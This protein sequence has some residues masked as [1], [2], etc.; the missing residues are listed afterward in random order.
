MQFMSNACIQGLLWMFK[1]QAA[2]FLRRLAW[3]Y[4]YSI[5][6]H[7]LSAVS[8]TASGELAPQCEEW[9]RKAIV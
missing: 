8:P 4:L 9:Y 2:L 5:E 1:K 7:N 6:N 3:F